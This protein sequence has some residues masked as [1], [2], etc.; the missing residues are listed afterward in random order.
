[1]PAERETPKKPAPAPATPTPA[2]DTALPTQATPASGV[3]RLRKQGPG[4]LTP[5]DVKNLQRS[6]G[7]R[8][9][10]RMMTAPRMIQRVLSAEE[11]AEKEK[12]EA[13]M[14]RIAGLLPGA[15]FREEKKPGYLPMKIRLAALKKK[16]GEPSAEDVEAERRVREEAAAARERE[17]RQ[18]Q[19]QLRPIRRDT[20]AALR[21]VKDVL[22]PLTE[23][24]TKAS[25]YEVPDM[26][27]VADRVSG[28]NTKVG[29][30]EH[31]SGAAG[32]V[33]AANAAKAKA[34]AMENEVAPLPALVQRITEQVEVL[35]AQIAAVHVEMKPLYKEVDDLSIAAFKLLTPVTTHALADKQAL[36][37]KIQAI[38]AKALKALNTAKAATKIGVAN[39]AKVEIAEE[40]TK[41][42]AAK[43]KAAEVGQ[44]EVAMASDTTHSGHVVGR[45]GPEISAKKVFDRHATGMTPDGVYSPAGSLSS[46]FNSYDAINSTL[47][48][49]K[50]KIGKA[51]TDAV[52]RVVPKMR[53]Y[54]DA[55]LAFETAQEA[56]ES[57]VPAPTPVV[58]V[59]QG[60]T[61]PPPVID[62][63]KADLEKERDDR[64]QEMAD[65]FDAVQ[66][67]VFAVN[68]TAGLCRLYFD[69]DETDPAKL[70]WVKAE[71]QIV[72]NHGAVIGKG[73]KSAATDETDHIDLKRTRTT[74]DFGASQFVIGGSLSV[75]TW[76]V[77]QHFPT[78]EATGIF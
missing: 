23:Q 38:K 30:I 43:E 32:T 5:N 52:N 37:L 26:A 20:S 78:N 45:H 27:A 39:Q 13:E 61:P 24:M 55:K 69:A 63:A 42:T 71:Y 58:T 10:Q 59:A 33:E 6:I 14:Q 17:A 74:F 25:G 70:V 2:T 3:Q 19:A 46:Q 73:F 9:V 47:K 31:E 12:I 22:S 77:A 44:K 18:L 29:Q 11:Q 57:Y 15:K 68:T 65:A 54:R 28:A 21:K 75:N 8:A 16:E 50:E 36:V 66:A 56:V 4:A 53:E 35:A 1:M 67:E 72:H 48:T 49:A 40:I 76:R 7:N 62:Q 64:Q 60:A 34:E 41:M 51:M